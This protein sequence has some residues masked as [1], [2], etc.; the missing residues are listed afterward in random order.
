MTS[1]LN[2]HKKGELL[3]LAGTAGFQAYVPSTIGASATTNN[4]HRDDSLRKAEL[5][6]SIDDYLQKNQT[7]LQ[8][9][10]AFEPY[11]ATKRSARPRQSIGN[12]TSDVEE[13]AKNVVRKTVK[14]ATKVKAELEYGRRLWMC[15][16]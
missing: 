14:K 4:S 7:T 15:S 9:K 1:W 6:S 13:S 12:V 8:G 10:E 11:Y 2:N 3:D 16:S 5:V